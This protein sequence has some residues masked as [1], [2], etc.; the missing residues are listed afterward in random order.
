MKLLASLALVAMFVL[1]IQGLQMKYVTYPT[2]LQAAR[3]LFAEKEARALRSG[4]DL[5]QLSTGI[6]TLAVQIEDDEKDMANL[7]TML[8]ERSKVVR[9]QRDAG[10]AIMTIMNET[11]M[12]K[13]Q[14]LVFKTPADCMNREPGLTGKTHDSACSF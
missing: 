6:M 7:Q 14:C 5:K 13:D 12:Q 4:K 10:K 2:H 9:L 3:E 1:S 8:V 11:M